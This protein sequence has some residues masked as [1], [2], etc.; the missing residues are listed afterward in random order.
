MRCHVIVLSYSKHGA[1][2]SFLFLF[3]L[4]K[5]VGFSGQCG[6]LA[7]DVFFFFDE[8]PASAASTVILLN[9]ACVHKINTSANRPECEPCC[10]LRG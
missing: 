1:V 5:N 3:F 2:L 8:Q 9:V 10:K 7:S 4:S 6:N